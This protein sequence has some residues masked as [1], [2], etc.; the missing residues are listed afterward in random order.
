MRSHSAFNTILKLTS[1]GRADCRR[2]S[3]TSDTVRTH[4]GPPDYT[5]LYVWE[6]SEAK[7]E[8]PATR[9]QMLEIEKC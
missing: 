2:T 7:I 3:S 9:Y 6:E 1:C 4:G 8:D 5:R